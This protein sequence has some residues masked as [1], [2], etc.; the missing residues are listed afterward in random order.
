MSGPLLRA[1]TS[2]GPAVGCHGVALLRTGALVAA[3]DV[4]A[5]EGAEDAGA[6]RTLVNVCA[7]NTVT[8]PAHKTNKQTNQKTEQNTDLQGQAAGHQETLT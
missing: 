2:A 8:A 7:K 3:G 5:A 1:V 6:L 4:D